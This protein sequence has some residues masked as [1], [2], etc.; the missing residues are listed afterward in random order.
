MAFFTMTA[1]RLLAR[2]WKQAKTNWK[3]SIFLLF[4]LSLAKPKAKR[5]ILKKVVQVKTKVLKQ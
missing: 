5:W 4:V 2:V 1:E 3:L